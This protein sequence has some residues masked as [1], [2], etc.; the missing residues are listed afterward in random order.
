MNL[1]NIFKR[2]QTEE[3]IKKSML[4]GNKSNLTTSLFMSAVVVSVITFTLKP[5]SM[6]NDNALMIEAINKR[7]ELKEKEKEA[8]KD[9]AN[10]RDYYIQTLKNKGLSREQIKLHIMQL[11]DKQK[12]AKGF[13][14]EE[15]KQ[16]Y[17]DKIIKLKE[18]QQRDK[19]VI[20]NLNVSV[21]K[22]KRRSPSFS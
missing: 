8:E 16:S 13:P 20:N 7:I 19:E 12:K 10:R 14:V 15:I 18:R 1:K 11:T 17:E 9:N 3:Q 4:K 21:N 6:T 5:D 2:K 22:N